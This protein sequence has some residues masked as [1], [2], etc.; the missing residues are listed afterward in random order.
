MYCWRSRTI[1]RIRPGFISGMFQLILRP[2]KALISE[3][4]YLNKT[5]KWKLKWPEL[6]VVP[7]GQ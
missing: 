3:D 4:V 2:N 6:T 5:R 1:S 7:W